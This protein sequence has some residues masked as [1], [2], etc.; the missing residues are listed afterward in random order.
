MDDLDLLVMH[1][2]EMWL[3][4]HPELEA[5]VRDSEEATR[6]WIKARLSEGRLIGFIVRTDGGA[7]AGSGCVWTRDEQPRPRN[8]R[9]RVAYLMSMYTAKDFRRRGVAKMVVK[10]AIEWSKEEGYDRVVLHASKEG[11]PLYE[12]FGFEPTSEMRLRL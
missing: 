3:D 1:R 11:R 9:H 12:E 10:S 8:P 2:L 4:I 7:V 6:D 5:D